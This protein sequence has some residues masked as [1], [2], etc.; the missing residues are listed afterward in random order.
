[1]APDNKTVYNS[2][3]NFLIYFRLKSNPLDGKI[4]DQDVVDKVTLF[5]KLKYD[6]SAWG[7][8]V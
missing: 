4:I 3:N 1:M 7:R 8:N 5:L 2:E 6:R